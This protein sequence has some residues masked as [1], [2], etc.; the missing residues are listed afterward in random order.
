M[1]FTRRE[2]IIIAATVAAI[3]LLVLD[4]Y[5]LRPLLRRRSAVVAEKARVVAELARARSL[6]NRRRLLGPKWRDMLD[7]GMMRDPTEAESQVLRLLRKW[8]TEAGVSISSL[9][10]ERSAEKSKLPE[11]TIHVAGTGS[12]AGVS[13]LL[14]QVETAQA[15]LKIKMLQLGSRKNGTDDLSINLKVSTLYVPPAPNRAAPAG[16][17]Q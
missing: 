16:G 11:I 7:N 14:W 5:A 4:F 6:L 8:S 13:R 3:C 17:D 10:P 2:K 9:R 1:V 12:M 15:P